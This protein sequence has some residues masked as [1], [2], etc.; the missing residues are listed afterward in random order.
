M[1][2]Y[3]YAGT[4]RK[5]LTGIYIYIYVA[6]STSN[7]AVIIIKRVRDTGLYMYFKD[8]NT[9]TMEKHFSKD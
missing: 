4:A 2:I 5:T 7:F 6:R 3:I 9:F 8:L 1:Y